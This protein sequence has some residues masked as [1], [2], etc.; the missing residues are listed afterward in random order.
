VAP[1]AQSEIGPELFEAARY[2]AMLEQAAMA[3]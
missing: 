2:Y 3:A 1:S